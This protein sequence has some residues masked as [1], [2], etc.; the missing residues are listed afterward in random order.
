MF[1]TYVA[2]I[3]L[4]NLFGPNT[5]HLAGGRRRSTS[6]PFGLVDLAFI[7]HTATMAS[8]KIEVGVAAVLYV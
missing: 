7:Y 6:S 4:T 1:S 3:D 2:D 8:A 5:F